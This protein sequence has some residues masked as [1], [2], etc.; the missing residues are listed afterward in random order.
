MSY[1]IW[2]SFN[3]KAEEFQL[4]VMPGRIELSDGN[5]GA[6]YDVAELGEINVIK[7]R[8]LT[9]CSFESIFPAKKYPFLATNNVLEPEQYIDYINRWMNSKRPIR[10]IF[11]GSTFGI[12]MAASIEAFT[13]RE[14]SGGMGDI[15]YSIR[16]K[17]YVMYAAKKV[18][19][20]TPQTST[21]SSTP[22]IEKQAPARPNDRI[23]PKEYTIKEGD[24]LWAIAKAQLG[25]GSLWTE[26]KSLNNITDA[27]VR[28]LQPGRVL[29]LP[30]A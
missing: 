29:V 8:K 25:N 12:N 4:P 2:L 23:P 16:L 3:N 27:E 19:I 17:K 9:E 22:V 10:F 15:E 7:D 20:K 14:V 13:W 5:K 21:Q 18:S 28:A 30:Y 26:I 11:T 6:T 24:T 1:G